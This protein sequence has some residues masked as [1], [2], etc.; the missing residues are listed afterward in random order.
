MQHRL[1][2]TVSNYT[3][4]VIPDIKIIASFT[5]MLIYEDQSKR[6]DYFQGPIKT[7]KMYI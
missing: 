4:I 3:I 1:L 5:S 7:T 6:L 2:A